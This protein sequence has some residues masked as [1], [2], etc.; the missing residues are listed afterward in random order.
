MLPIAI[1]VQAKTIANDLID[2]VPMGMELNQISKI[3]EDIEI[4]NRNIR[5]DNIL[6]DNETKELTIEDHE[7]YKSSIPKGNLFYMDFKY[8]DDK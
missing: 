6:N 2:V 8:G 5:I 3:K 1:K 7:D 4:R